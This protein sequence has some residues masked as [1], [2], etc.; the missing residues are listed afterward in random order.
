MVATHPKASSPPQTEL[1]TRFLPGAPLPCKR[2][3]GAFLVF[4]FS[5]RRKLLFRPISCG[6]CGILLSPAFLDKLT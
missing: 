4:Y 3:A 5:F 6:I 1:R 2:A